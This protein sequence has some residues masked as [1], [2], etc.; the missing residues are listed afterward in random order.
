MSEIGIPYSPTGD[1]VGSTGSF[2]FTPAPQENAVL[3][4]VLFRVWSSVTGAGT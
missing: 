3:G 2:H 4:L 1:L